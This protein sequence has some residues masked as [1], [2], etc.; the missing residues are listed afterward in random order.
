[1][2]ECLN[3]AERNL[4]I[5]VD[6]EVVEVQTRVNNTK[7]NIYLELY[8]CS[9]DRFQAAKVCSCAF[10]ASQ[11]TSRI[12]SQASRLPEK[13]RLGVYSDC[14]VNSCSNW[15]NDNWS[16][17][18]LPHIVWTF[19]RFVSLQSAG[20]RF[21]FL[22]P[23]SGTT[24]LSISHLRRHSRHYCLD[25]CGP[26]NNEHYLVRKSLCWWWTDDEWMTERCLE[27]QVHACCCRTWSQFERSETNSVDRR[28]DWRMRS[29]I[30]WTDSEAKWASLCCWPDRPACCSYWFLI[31]Y[32]PSTVISCPTNLWQVPRSLLPRKTV[33]LLLKLCR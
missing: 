15:V 1:M 29:R 19:R 14:T 27:W 22:V 9:S 3:T 16:C 17:G 21:R 31:M 11:K 7:L 24:C 4:K 13:I 28:R 18:L 10:T 33:L 30:D 25:T 12:F 32:Q 20:G 2:N 6:L 5:E 26:C 23:P 8:F